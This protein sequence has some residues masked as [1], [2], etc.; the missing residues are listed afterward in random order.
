MIVLV[1]LGLAIV[2]AKVAAPLLREGA[3]ADFIA[4][5]MMWAIG[6]GLILARIAGVRFPPVFTVMARLFMRIT[7]QGT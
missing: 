5:V 3:W 2:A 1:F 7:Q 4:F 6:S